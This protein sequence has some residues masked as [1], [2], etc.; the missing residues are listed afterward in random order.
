VY[1]GEGQG[2]FGTIFVKVEVDTTQIISVS[3]GE[4]RETPTIAA[5]AF[6][7]IPAQIVERQSLVVDNVAG[8]TITSNGIISGVK[9]AL[10]SAG[11]TEEQLMAAARR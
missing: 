5:P 8:A 9:A 11:A 1:T 3:I 7:R 4:N 6:N 10:L 2:F